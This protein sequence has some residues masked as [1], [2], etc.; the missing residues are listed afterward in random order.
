M[1]RTSNN[2]FLCVRLRLWQ[3]FVKSLILFPWNTATL[4]IVNGYRDTVALR[5]RAGS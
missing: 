4:Y 1:Y 5:L 3:L 2:P